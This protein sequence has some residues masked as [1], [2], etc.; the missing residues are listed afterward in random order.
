MDGGGR[1]RRPRRREIERRRV[2]C[3]PVG[4]RT[5][6]RCTETEESGMTSPLYADLP[7]D[8]SISFV[9]FPP[10][11]A[12][13]EETLWQSIQTPAPLRPRFLTVNHGAGGSTRKPTHSTVGRIRRDHGLPPAAHP[14]QS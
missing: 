11:T 8:V 6:C 10:K 13:M 5:G 3:H 1:A 7:G 14:P 9:F 4:G 12:T 2:D